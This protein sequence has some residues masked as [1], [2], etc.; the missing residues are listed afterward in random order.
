MDILDLK[1][2]G[3]ENKRGYRYVLVVIDNFSKFSLTIHVKNKNAETV[4]DSFENFLISSKKASLIETDRGKEF[5]III[6]RNSLNNNSI[7]H[8]SRNTSLGAVF[9]K[10][11]NRTVRDLLER[12]VFGNGDGNWVDVLHTKTKQFSFFY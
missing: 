10:R 5:C 11:F 9:A 1:E 4:R 7:K 3:T 12:L 8:F 2:Y 6:F